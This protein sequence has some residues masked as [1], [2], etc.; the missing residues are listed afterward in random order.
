MT[1]VLLVCLGNIC[2]S[3]MAEGILRDLA[4]K[5]NIEIELDSAGTGNSHIGQAPDPRS[6]STVLQFGIDIS[7][8]RARQFTVKD[9]NNFDIIYV[10]DKSNQTDVLKLAR[11]SEDEKKVHLFLD[12]IK[13]N[14]SK[15]VP[16][17]WFGNLD[18]FKNVFHLLYTASENYVAHYNTVKS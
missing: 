2:R 9:F 7:Q 12:L 4:K 13:N 1:R 5:N 16:D 6:I 8:L 14:K 3:P 11:S 15:D 10:M 17:P 18:E